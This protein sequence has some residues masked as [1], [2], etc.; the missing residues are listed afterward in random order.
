MRSHT[1]RQE[2]KANRHAKM[3]ADRMHEYRFVQRTQQQNTQRQKWMDWGNWMW[4]SIRYESCGNLEGRSFCEK[5]DPGR[6]IPMTAGWNQPRDERLMV[7]EQ[8]FHGLKDAP[9]ARTWIIAIGQSPTKSS[10]HM[11]ARN[12]DTHLYPSRL[13]STVNKE[14]TRPQS[15]TAMNQ[16]CKAPTQYRP[17]KMVL[18]ERNLHVIILMKRKLRFQN[19]PFTHACSQ[20]GL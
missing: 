16:H 4:S 19:D 8:V 1:N 5:S 14:I 20:T 18:P 11:G 13:A 15:L 17:L 3:A 7:A 12:A 2:I 10:D 9:N 6:V